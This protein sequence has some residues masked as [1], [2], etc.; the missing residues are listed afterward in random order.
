MG[1]KEVGV[2]HKGLQCQNCGEPY[3]WSEYFDYM[4]SLKSTTVD[5]FKCPAENY[6]VARKSGG[7]YFAKLVSF[8]IT[9]YLEYKWR[10]EPW[11]CGGAFRRRHCLF[12]RCLSRYNENRKLVDWIL[13]IGQGA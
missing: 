8:D 6:V 12:D 11:R 4:M 7:Y 3:G 13:V 10:H 5:C 2:D 1:K 9:G